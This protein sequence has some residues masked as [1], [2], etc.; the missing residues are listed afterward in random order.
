MSGNFK[1]APFA[2]AI[3]IVD[4]ERSTRQAL[5]ELFHQLGYKASQAASGDEALNLLAEQSYDVVVLDLRMPGKDGVAVLAVAEEI[6]PDS[7]FIVFTA[8]ASTDTAIAALRSGA[9]DYL[10][11]PCS[12]Q[13]IAEAVEKAL[14]KQQAH[15][16]QKKALNLLQQVVDTLQT[17]DSPR[18]KY[19]AAD[20]PTDFILDEQQ[21]L[22]LYA[23]KLLDLTPTEYKILR[24]FILQPN[25]L[26]DYVTLAQVSHGVMVD[27][28]EARTLLRT[29]LYRLNTKLSENRPSPLKLVRGKG[30]IL[31]TNPTDDYHTDHD[32]HPLDTLK[33]NIG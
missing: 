20:K 31:T 11:K 14:E 15:K 30:F 9:V 4:D 3:L 1:K 29:H 6:A 33:V 10:Q 12:L 25:T 28:A 22:I 32:S 8:Y 21:Q 18:A 27:E 7:A 13:T 16:R 2:A 17:E 19:A 23:N 26:F 5:G 24:H